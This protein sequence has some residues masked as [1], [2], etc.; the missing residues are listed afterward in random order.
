[1]K[2]F[3]ID[4][5]GRHRIVRDR[6]KPT[7]AANEVLVA[8]RRVGFCG[9]DL[10]TFRGSNPNVRYPRVPGHEIA[11]KIVHKGADVPRDFRIGD[12]VTI[13]PYT[14]CGNCSSCQNDR[15]NA[16]KFNQ[17]LGVQRDGAMSEYLAVSHEKLIGGVNQ[18]SF[19]EIALIEPLSVGFHA[20]SRAQPKQGE[21]LIVLGCGLVGI[22]VIAGASAAGAKVIAVDIDDRKLALAGKYGAACGIN[23]TTRN[24]EREVMALTDGHGAAVVVEAVGLART[25]VSAIDL[26]AFSG[27]VV[28]VGYVK[29]AVAFETKK[30][31]MKEIEIRGSRNALRSD[32]ENV[33][34][35]MKSGKPPLDALI[36]MKVPFAEAGAAL[37]RWA[38][39]PQAIT[40]ILVSFDKDSDGD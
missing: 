31:V 19:D 30:F 7:I 39:N 2:A 10:N 40:K 14:S 12:K 23:A 18:L 6:E 34:K 20:A 38:D 11:G 21:T 22:G 32:F 15:P 3:M 35:F 26:V 4:R 24:L 16:C 5:P 13:L 29:D 17:T 33:L 37:E 28:Y 25:F 36:S 1:M 9:S 8:V 27:R